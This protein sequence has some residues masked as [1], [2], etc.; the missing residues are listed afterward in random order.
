[1]VPRAAPE[2]QEASA[3]LGDTAGTEEREGPALS[4]PGQRAPEMDNKKWLAALLEEA[5]IKGGK[6]SLMVAGILMRLESTHQPAR[7][8]GDQRGSGNWRGR[9]GQ[10]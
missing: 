9:S 7:R 3:D 5:G 10:R 8:P 6:R 1:M 4:D 2:Q